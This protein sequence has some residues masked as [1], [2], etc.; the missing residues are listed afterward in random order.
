[1]ES[2]PAVL[3]PADLNLETAELNLEPSLL[4]L[5]SEPAVLIPADLNLETAVLNLESWQLRLKLREPS[6]IRKTNK[7]KMGILYLAIQ[8]ILNPCIG[9]TQKGYSY[10]VKNQMKCRIMRHFIRVYTVC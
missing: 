9:E 4:C 1:M 5:E 8:S 2:G 10:T 6:D 7:F 3:I